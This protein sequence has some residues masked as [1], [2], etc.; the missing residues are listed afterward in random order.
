MKM[1]VSKRLSQQ[2]HMRGVLGID[3]SNYTTSLCLLDESGQIAFE[4]RQVLEVPLGEQGLMQSAALFQHVSNL[5]ELF[6]SARRKLGSYQILGVGVSSRPRKVT[7]SYMPVFKAGYLAA[8]SVA[9]GAHVPLIETS[10]QS[11]HLMAGIVTAKMTLSE[12]ETFL[13]LHLSGGT[14]DV[15][16]VKRVQSDFEVEVLTSSRDLHIGQYVDRI[17]VKLGLSFPAG[18]Q[19]EQLAKEWGDQDLPLIPSA[20]HNGSPSFSGPLSAA[21]RLLQ[22]GVPRAAIAASVQRSIATTLEKMLRHAFATTGL[23]RALLVGGV[24]SNQYISDRLKKRLG[25]S[26]EA[27]SSLY[28]CDPHYASDNA[29]G[30]A[31]IALSTLQHSSLK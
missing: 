13:A 21:E 4:Q 3:T 20:V 16:S 22:K 2:A 11:G 12:G 26:E 10:H 17:G 31:H 27:H 14:T 28:F 7:G 9:F 5:P 1:Q 29:F 25:I 6:S 23:R 30:V 15:L 8:Q 19:L 24:A 18:K